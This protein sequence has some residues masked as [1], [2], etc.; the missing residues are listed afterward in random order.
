MKIATANMYAVMP[1]LAAVALDEND[2]AIDGS[3]VV[4]TVP[5]KFSMKYADA[6]ISGTIARFPLRLSMCVFRKWAALCNGD[7]EIGQAV[8]VT[9]HRLALLHRA[10]A[11]GRA[12]EDQVA[13]R[14]FHQPGERRDRLGDTPDQ[15]GEV[16]FL[17]RLVVHLQPDRALRRMPDLRHRR[18][19]RARRGL[20]ETLR[21]VP[22]PLHLLGHALHVAPRHVEPHRIAIDEVQRL[23]HGHIAAAPLERDHHFDL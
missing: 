11:L 2:R 23:F 14:Q 6:T 10:D 3:A 13:R 15:L 17:A 1:A 21:H 9:M 7:H 4:I 19:G 16:A 18:D 20:V 12:A 8:D 5:S 22:W